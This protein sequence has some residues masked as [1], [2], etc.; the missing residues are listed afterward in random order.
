[1]KSDSIYALAEL[2][3]ASTPYGLIIACLIIALS[4]INASEK[5]IGDRFAY[6]LGIATGLA[7]AA[8]GGYSPSQRQQPQTKVNHADQVDIDQSK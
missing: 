5:L 1:M 6:A 8:A 7:S 2:V 4:A 3:R